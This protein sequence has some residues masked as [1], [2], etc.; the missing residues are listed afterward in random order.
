MKVMDCRYRPTTAAWMNTFV[1]NPV[2]AEYVKITGFDKKTVK[3]LAGCVAQLTELGIEKAVITG[4]DIES[5]FATPSSNSLV[6]ESVAAYPSLFIGVYGYD[7]Y[8]GMKGYKAMRKA[9]E[10]KRSVGASIEPGMSKCSVDSALYYPLYALCC[11]HDVPVMVTA[12]LSPHMPGVLLDA[13]S[14]ARLDRVASDF[15][16]LRILISHGGYPWV[17]E[18]IA[19]CMRHSNVFIDFSSAYNKPMGKQYIRAAKENLSERFVFSSANPFA[20]VDKALAQFM[21]MGFEGEVLENILY[22]NAQH[23]FSNLS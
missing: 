22:R 13:T 2:Y 1:K 11:D 17:N 10:E 7:P 16:E 14:P 8:K 19:V 21:Q 23:L 3:D 15:P 5:T 4:R 12:G 18:T 20:D 9:L 6:D